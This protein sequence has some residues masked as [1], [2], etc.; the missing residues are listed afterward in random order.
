MMEMSPSH[1]ITLLVYVNF[2]RIQRKFRQ[3]FFK[4]CKHYFDTN[5]NTIQYTDVDGGNKQSIEIET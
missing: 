3:T 1:L 2:D 5:T 4:V